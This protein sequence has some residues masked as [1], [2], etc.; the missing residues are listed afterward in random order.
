MPILLDHLG[1]DIST[2][3]AADIEQITSC[4]VSILDRLGGSPAAIVAGDFI[5]FSVAGLSIEPIAPRALRV[6]VFPDRAQAAAWLQT[7]AS[8]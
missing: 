2:L 8:P 5:A 1:L 4:V 6:R 7:I 3:T